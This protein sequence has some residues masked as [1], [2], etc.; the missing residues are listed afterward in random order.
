MKKILCLMITIEFCLSCSDFLDKAPL[1]SPSDKTFLANKKE[2]EMSIAGCYTHLWT[3][4]EG[5][6]FFLAFEELSDNGWERNTND[7]Q[8]L[9][10]GANDAQSSFVRTVWSTCYSGI[11]RCNYL[12]NKTNNTKGIEADFIAQAQAQAKFL[13]AYYYSYLIDLYCDVPLIL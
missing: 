3:G 7:V 9:S 1:D 12:I 11:S 2:I 4:W 5:M 8:K 13:R 6:A 10:Q